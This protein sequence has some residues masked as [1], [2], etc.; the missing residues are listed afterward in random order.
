MYIYAL[1]VCWIRHIKYECKFANILGNK[2]MYK[3]AHRAIAK[4]PHTLKH[5]FLII[6]KEK[7]LS[8]NP[9]KIELF[10]LYMLMQFT[11]FQNLCLFALLH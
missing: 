2:N 10:E 11:S 4:W 3:I 5:S 6:K 8:L 9:L 7:W 1:Y